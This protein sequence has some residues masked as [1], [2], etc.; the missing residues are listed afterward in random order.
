MSNNIKGN[1]DNSGLDRLNW[2]PD[3]TK[4]KEENEKEFRQRYFEI[5]GEYP[6]ESEGKSSK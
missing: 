5:Y 2:Q 4:S 1:K 3:Y 6:P